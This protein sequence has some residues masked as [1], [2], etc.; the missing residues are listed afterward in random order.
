MVK[1]VCNNNQL[2]DL[3]FVLKRPH[4][5]IL[6]KSTAKTVCMFI[7][8]CPGNFSNTHIGGNK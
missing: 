6:F 4:P 2:H 7:P 5:G 3:P 8:H 1:T